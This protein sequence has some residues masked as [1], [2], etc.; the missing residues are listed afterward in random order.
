M[1]SSR[2][3]FL[4]AL[5]AGAVLAGAAS[6]ALGQI[7][8]FW[9]SDPVSGSGKIQAGQPGGSVQDRCRHLGFVSINHFVPEG[10]IVILEL[11]K[12]L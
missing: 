1:Q 8:V 12:F 2:Q 10:L 11:L 6:S 9:T 7:T 4:I 5:V 3:T